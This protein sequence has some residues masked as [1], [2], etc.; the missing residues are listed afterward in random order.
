MTGVLVFLPNPTQT[1]KEIFRVL[2]KGGRFV[3]F[4][5]SK[6]L[7]GTPA[8]PEP[9]ASRL[10]FYEDNEIEDMATL[11]GFDTVRVEHPSLFEQAKKAGVPDSE[12]DL[13]R[14][15]RGSQLLIARKG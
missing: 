5:S 6:E 9:I 1:F 4:T 10:H 15:T 2:R 13:F 8:A 11:A 12:L 7:R 14:G 3:A